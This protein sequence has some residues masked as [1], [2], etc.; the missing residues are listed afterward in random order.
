[1]G[2]FFFF[3]SFV[4]SN[5]SVKITNCF[6]EKMYTH[7]CSPSPKCKVSGWKSSRN[8]TRNREERSQSSGGGGGNKVGARS[9]GALNAN[10]SS[11]NVTQ[12]PVLSPGSKDRD[13]P[14]LEG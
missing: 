10:P 8:G 4:F 9:A 14:L 6:E 1:M 13:L 2:V 5:S 7:P 12:K 3:I 11:W